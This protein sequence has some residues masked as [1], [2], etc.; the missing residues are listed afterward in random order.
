MGKLDGAAV[1]ELDL[2]RLGR[3]APRD[4]DVD[5]QVLVSVS[6][7]ELLRLDRAQHGLDHSYVRA[8]G[9]RG[10]LLKRYGLSFRRSPRR[11][12]HRRAGRSIH[13]HPESVN[14]VMRTL[15]GLRTPSRGI[16]YQ[17]GLM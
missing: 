2:A 7:P 16:D 5:Q 9:Y 4:P 17:G 11:G 3:D 13:W 8:Y 6:H 10:L 14:G 1:V 15:S 12:R